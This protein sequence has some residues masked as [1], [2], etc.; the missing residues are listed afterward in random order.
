MGEVKNELEVTLKDT[1][2]EEWTDAFNT[3]RWKNRSLSHYTDDEDAAKSVVLKAVKKVA[4][5]YSYKL[6]A[7]HQAHLKS[8]VTLDLTPA[9]LLPKLF[10]AMHRGK[11]CPPGETPTLETVQ[12]PDGTVQTEWV[13]RKL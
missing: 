2:K 8:Q 7:G 12:H 9:K 4:K 3:L 6:T 13:C 10:T 5:T 11:K 1:I